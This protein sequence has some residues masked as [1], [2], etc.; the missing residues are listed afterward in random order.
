[1]LKPRRPAP[2][3]PSPTAPASSSLP[4]M[5]NAIEHALRQ[6]TIGNWANASTSSLASRIEAAALGKRASRVSATSSQRAETAAGSDRAKIVRNAA[7][8]MS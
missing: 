1:M 8:T 6:C 7:E 4:R 5:A 2:M 3:E